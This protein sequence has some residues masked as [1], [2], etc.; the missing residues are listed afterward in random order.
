MSAVRLTSVWGEY[1]NMKV[2]KLEMRNIILLVM[3]NQLSFSNS[4]PFHMGNV[5]SKIIIQVS[6]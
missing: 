1:Q 6:E 5:S 2:F 4:F 3:D